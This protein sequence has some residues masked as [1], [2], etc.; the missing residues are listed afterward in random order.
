VTYPDT[1]SAACRAYAKELG[2]TFAKLT[3]EL[4]RLPIREAL[5]SW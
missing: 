2:D 1:V 3:G 5:A 4:Q